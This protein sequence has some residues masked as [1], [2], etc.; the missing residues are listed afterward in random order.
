MAY[1]ITFSS[2]P[3]KYVYLDSSP[4]EYY[5]RVVYGGGDDVPALIECTLTIRQAGVTYTETVQKTAA[6]YGTLEA[7]FYFDFSEI[8]KKY[9]YPVLAFADIADTNARHLNIMDCYFQPS[10]QLFV[11]DSTTGLIESEG[12]PFTPSIATVGAIRGRFQTDN[13]TR[14]INDYLFLGNS[15]VTSKSI[16][17]TRPNGGKIG[18]L[19]WE[20]AALPVMGDFFASSEPLNGVR[21]VSTMPNGTT[22]ISTDFLTFPN[23]TTVKDDLYYIVPIG[24]ANLTSLISA[25]A[26]SYTVQFGFKAAIGPGFTVKYAA[27]SRVITTCVP[28]A[29]VI[30]FNSLGGIDFFNFYFERV[31]EYEADRSTYSKQHAKLFYS[32]INVSATGGEVLTANS[33]QKIK[34][35]TKCTTEEYAWLAKE[36]LLSGKAYI[37]LENFGIDSTLIPVNLLSSNVEAYNSETAEYFT[38]FEFQYSNPILSL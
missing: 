33:L 21:V 32:H 3:T 2:Q 14:D 25:G 37:M 28:E 29:K 18:A 20:V 4:I 22:N 5:I 19:E 38:N 16:L 36:L 35:Q 30:F 11:E 34:L 24:T 9:T 17:S 15:G 7:Y 23:N 27:I 31:Q 26:V 8:V 13:A 12:S 10:F 6:V 1:T